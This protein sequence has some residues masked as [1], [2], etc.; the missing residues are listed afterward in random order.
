MWRHLL[1][2]DKRRP[3]AQPVSVKQ[4]IFFDSSKWAVTVAATASLFYTVAA[5][6]GNQST[7]LRTCLMCVV[8]L[9]PPLLDKPQGFLSFNG[10]GIA[11]SRDGELVFPLIY[12]AQLFVPL[13]KPK[14]KQNIR[15]SK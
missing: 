12:K 5:T 6:A 10:V 9:P 4:T 3:Q 8:P 13:K 7:Q 2:A 1:I 15:G 11:T 14:T